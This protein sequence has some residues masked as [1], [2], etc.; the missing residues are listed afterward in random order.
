MKHG[1]LP[2]NTLRLS[3]QL[4]YI[5]LQTRLP[6]VQTTIL[7][8]KRNYKLLW[9]GF[10]FQWQFKC[11]LIKISHVDNMPTRVYRTFVSG[12]FDP[13]KIEYFDRTS[14]LIVRSSYSWIGILKP[15]YHGTTSYPPCW[16]GKNTLYFLIHT[17]FN[18]LRLSENQTNWISLNACF[19]R[20][21]H[22]RQYTDE[23]QQAYYH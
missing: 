13:I 4:V 20:Q 11:V 6:Y 21:R 9:G 19:W 22:W 5:W 17:S 10:Y 2:L 3:G 23:L 12:R 15:V 16:C 18:M 8:A 7:N 14:L 1:F